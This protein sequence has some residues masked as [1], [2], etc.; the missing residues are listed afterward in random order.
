MAPKDKDLIP[1]KVT[2]WCST[3]DCDDDHI[4]EF[5]KTFGER[6]MEHLKVP[7]HFYDHC[8]TTGHTTTIQYRREE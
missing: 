4:S 7:F 5:S 8:N 2:F 1:N 6:F 3:V